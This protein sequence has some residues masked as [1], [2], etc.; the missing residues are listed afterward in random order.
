MTA[1]EDTP[2]TTV[3]RRWFEDLFTRG[4]TAVADE[5]LDD[6]V[7]YHGPPSLSPGDVTGVEDISGGDDELRVRWSATGTHE[8]ELFG[9]EPTGETFTVEG[10]NTFIIEGGRIT[11]VRAQ[12]DT[13]KMVQEYPEGTTSLQKTCCG[14]ANTGES[15]HEN[16]AN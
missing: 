12:W 3:V 10:I 9:M 14:V 15:V 2:D 1:P 13:L 4:D 16:Y 6:D 5:I 7:A 11:E 8:S